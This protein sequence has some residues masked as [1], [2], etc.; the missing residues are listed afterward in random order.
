MERQFFTKINKDYVDRRDYVYKAPPKPLKAKVDLRFWTSPVEDQGQLG[1][2]TGNALVGAYECLVNE[3]DKQKFVNLS[4]LFVYY[5]E[6]ELEGTVQ[7]D[8]GASLRD[9]IKCL[10]KWG[11]CKES[12]WPYDITQ[13][14]VKPSEFCY[15]EAKLR[16]ITSF[17][18]LNNL[19]DVL[20]RLSEGK[21]VVIGA[22]IFNSIYNVTK[23]NPIIPVPTTGDYMLGGHAMC[24]VGYD[25][26]RKLLLVRNS[27]GTAWGDNGYGWM[28]F[29]YFN[30]L[31]QGIDTWTFDINPQPDAAK[32]MAPIVSI[33]TKIKAF[34]SK[35]YLKFLDAMG[36]YK[37]NIE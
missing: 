17:A 9:G 11:V 19:T 22:P 20:G 34:F 28:P 15:Q 16:T 25:L 35:L 31:H 13:Y 4:R 30:G 36:S 32:A 29:D 23:K 1:S 7:T 5:N 33:W 8:A 6:R 21:P 12:L 3:Q 26:T 27:W 18:R 2:C 24:I 10:R 14:K 37:G